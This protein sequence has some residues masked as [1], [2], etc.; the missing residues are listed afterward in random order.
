MPTVRQSVPRARL[1]IAREGTRQAPPGCSGCRAVGYPGG[2]LRPRE[3]GKLRPLSA[4]TASLVKHSAEDISKD[5]VGFQGTAPRAAFPLHPPGGEAARPQG[6]CAIFNSRLHSAATPGRPLSASRCNAGQLQGEGAL[7]R[8]CALHLPRLLPGT[9]TALY[10]HNAAL[11]IEKSCL[12]RH[13][14]SDRSM[15]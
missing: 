7:H 10:Y 6:T 4:L 15:N 12:A 5:V 2:C 14:Q 9:A 3:I 13:E 8:S 1:R 11:P